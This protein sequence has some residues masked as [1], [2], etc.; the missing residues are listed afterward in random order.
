MEW[1]AVVLALQILLLAAGWL[2]FQ[3][4]RGELSARAAE[5]PVLTE[6]RALHKSVKVLLDELEAAAARQEL[7]FEQRSADVFAAVAEMDA[8][9]SDAEGRLAA[10]EHRALAIRLPDE[11]GSLPAED[12]ARERAVIVTGQPGHDITLERCA[13]AP[14]YGSPAQET[15]YPAEPVSEAESRR[16]RILI[17]ASCGHTIAA[18]AQAARVSEGEVE[19]VLSLRSGR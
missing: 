15:G 9:L 6:M 14:D 12:G 2:L 10:Y 8:R 13:P 16:Q 4:A 17:L 5:A 1:Q 18:I 19:T 11:P 3:R 7:D